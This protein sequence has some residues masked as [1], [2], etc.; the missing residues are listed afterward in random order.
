VSKRRACGQDG[1]GFALAVGLACGSTARLGPARGRAVLANRLGALGVDAAKPVDEFVCGR[2]AAGSP[3]PFL[4]HSPRDLTGRS[5]LQRDPVRG[6]VPERTAERCRPTGSF[7]VLVRVLD[8]SRTR[9]GI[10]PEPGQCNRGGANRCRRSRWIG[11]ASGGTTWA[12]WARLVPAAGSGNAVMR[13]PSTTR[14][15]SPGSGAS[16]GGQHREH[17]SSVRRR[18]TAALHLMYRAGPGPDRGD[19]RARGLSRSAF[20]I[21]GSRAGRRKVVGGPVTRRAGRD[22]GKMARWVT[23]VPAR[24]CE[25]PARRASP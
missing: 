5:R 18:C 11:G 8:G 6:Q 16:Y 20:P 25:G 21:V 22:A 1:T 17:R 15:R 2:S 14:R 23:P 7:R 24:W 10:R 9:V 13:W 4:R 19:R 12:G 3:S